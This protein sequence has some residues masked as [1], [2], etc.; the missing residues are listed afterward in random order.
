MVNGMW[1][2]MLEYLVED[3]EGNQKYIWTTMDNKQSI[4]D[5]GYKII[6]R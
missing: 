4:Y 6:S 3:Q 2:I 1:K 5:M